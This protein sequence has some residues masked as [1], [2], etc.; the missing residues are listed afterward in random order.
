MI[1]G[2]ASCRL[3]AS[4]A[5]SPDISRAKWATV[6]MRKNSGDTWPPVVCSVVSAM[7]IA[8][9]RVAAQL[10]EA[11]VHAD[12]IEF[13]QLGPDV[14][15]L[16]LQFAARGD[17]GCIQVWPHLTGQRQRLAV[18]TLPEVVSGRAGSTTKRAGIM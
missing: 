16:L 15:D 9:N 3:A 12:R 13:Q 2:V 10:E 18:A 14:G 17:E 1:S 4:V 8:N 11:V 6:G 5:V 7:R